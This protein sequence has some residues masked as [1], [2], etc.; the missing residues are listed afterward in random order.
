MKKY[1]NKMK[2]GF[3]GRKLNSK[4]KYVVKRKQHDKA[5]NKY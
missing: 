5:T 2:K 1:D 4:E 3:P